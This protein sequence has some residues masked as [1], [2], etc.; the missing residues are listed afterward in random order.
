MWRDPWLKKR[1]DS[2]VRSPMVVG[3]EHLRVK[4]L[5]DLNNIGLNVAL[6]D[7]LFNN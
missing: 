3:T 7:Q 4:N 1:T 6:I 2:F 5:W